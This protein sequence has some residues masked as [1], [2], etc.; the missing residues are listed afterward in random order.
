[1]QGSLKN[2]LSKNLK[3]RIKARLR[4]ILRLKN[5]AGSETARCRIRL[6]KYCIG[7]GLDLG[8]GGDPIIPEA[9]TVD[10]PQ[11][12]RNTCDAPLNLKGDAR[13]L[14]WFKDESLDY[15]FSSHLL[16]DFPD[17]ETVLKEWLR[18]LKKGGY[19]ILY[20]P[21][22]QLYRQHCKKTN[23]PYNK[24][25]KIKDFS[26]AYILNF[27]KKIANIEIVHSNPLC[28][29]YSFEIVIK[30]TN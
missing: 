25:H 3:Q 30:K 12:Y 19:L 9:I 10:L 24:N 23:Q 1:M 17:T 5:P 27:I 21:D 26:L 18:V 8:Y 16:E 13:D 20:C 7:N 22:E 15:V 11:P 6:K 29:D 2:M 4:K 28:E 14:Y